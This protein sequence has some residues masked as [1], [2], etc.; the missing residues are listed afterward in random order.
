LFATDSAEFKPPKKERAASDEEFA[1][2]LNSSHESLARLLR[3]SRVTRVRPY[4][5]LNARIEAFDARKSRLLLEERSVT[6]RR[7]LAREVALKEDARQILSDAIGDRDRGL[8]FL[9]A[10]GRPWALGRLST[11][12]VQARKRAGL[13]PEIVL[14]GRGGNVSKRV[15]EM[16]ANHKIVDVR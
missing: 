8:I 10:T 4:D 3:F 6:G 12:F 9:T 1:T 7:I 13:S 2:L 11:T 5:L 14:S 15:G 16:S